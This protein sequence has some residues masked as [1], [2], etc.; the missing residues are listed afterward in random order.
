MPISTYE[1]LTLL[2]AIANE[3]RS[4][5]AAG[6]FTSRAGYPIRCRST[7]EPDVSDRAAALREQRLRRGGGGTAG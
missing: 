4:V 7:T 2:V 6:E 5:N 1:R 3:V